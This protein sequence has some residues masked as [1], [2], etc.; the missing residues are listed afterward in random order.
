MSK[1]CASPPLLLDLLMSKDQLGAQVLEY[2]RYGDLQRLTCVNRALAK[3]LRHDDHDTSSRYQA[4]RMWLRELEVL[5]SLKC[6]PALLRKM[7]A[8]IRAQNFRV[9][10]YENRDM[11]RPG[12]VQ[13]VPSRM[14][15]VLE[16]Y[17][18]QSLFFDV[19]YFSF[20]TVHY[21]DLEEWGLEVGVACDDVKK[22]NEE[23]DEDD[24]D[25]HYENNDQPPN[26]RQRQML[27][28]TSIFCTDSS[29]VTRVYYIRQ[30]P[31]CGACLDRDCFLRLRFLCRA[32][33]GLRDE[34]ERGGITV[35]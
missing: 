14:Y 5:Y 27:T 7:S 19:S 4:I 1:V 13:G 10:A 22:P 25:N 18:E 8:T 20:A 16:S 6:P 9:L 15:D 17:W 12:P 11:E 30:T 23:D 31:Y 35:Q 29:N 3:R 33:P 28:C 34:M 2:L 24:G 26:K 32:L 21:A